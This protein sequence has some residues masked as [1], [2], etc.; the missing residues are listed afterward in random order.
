MPFRLSLYRA[1]DGLGPMHTWEHE[2]RQPLGTRSDLKAALGSVL[3]GLRWEESEGLLFASCPF[4]GD[5]HACEIWLFGEPTDTLFDIGVYALPPAIRAIMSGLG[6]N[7]CY[8]QE[9]G[10]RRFPF[11]AGDHWPTVPLAG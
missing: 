3:E 9:S 6:L 2:C 11:E 7:Y 10:E 4:D 1:A 5:E 8:A